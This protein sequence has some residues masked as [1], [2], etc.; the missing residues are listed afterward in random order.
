M[1]LPQV[2][3]TQY[4]D[5]YKSLFLHI[6]LQTNKEFNTL[7]E[8]ATELT[9]EGLNNTMPHHITVMRLLG[10]HKKQP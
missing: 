2:W 4:Y 8:L 6:L 7:H 5:L 3:Y 9:E 1:L 10:E